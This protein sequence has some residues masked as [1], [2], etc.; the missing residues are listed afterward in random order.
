[1][2]TYLNRKNLSQARL[3]PSQW[4]PK[5]DWEARYFFHPAE[6]LVHPTLLSVLLLSIEIPLLYILFSSMAFIGLLLYFW[7]GAGHGIHR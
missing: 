1:M 5:H 7:H 4:G 6:D 2:I 3:W